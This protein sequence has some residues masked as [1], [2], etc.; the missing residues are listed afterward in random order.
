MNKIEIACIIDDDDI[1]VFGIKKLIEMHKYCENILVF[2]NGEEAIKYL[3]PIVTQTNE[4]PDIILL[5]IN[6]PVMDGWSFME[7]FVKLKPQINKQ[8]TIYMV[9]SSIHDEDVNKAK[10]FTEISDYIVKPIK[11]ADLKRMFVKEEE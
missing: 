4:L 8:I 6:M 9:S 2:K 1:Y 7:E 3:T 11:S 10:L 5:D